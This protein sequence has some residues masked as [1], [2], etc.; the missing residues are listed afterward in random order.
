MFFSCEAESSALVIS[1][2][3]PKL[4]PTSHACGSREP[5][6]KFCRKKQF[7]WSSLGRKNYLLHHVCYLTDAR[8]NKSTQSSNID[9]CV[10]V[11][12]VRLVLCSQ[13]HDLFFGLQVNLLSTEQFVSLPVRH[14]QSHL[15]RKSRC[16]NE[17]Q[18]KW[19]TFSLFLVFLVS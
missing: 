12:F 6:I 4:N 15:K 14:L 8:Y 11:L 18:H 3:T 9:L 1:N 2:V 13:S 5:P 7:V 19:G 10:K 16:K 17:K